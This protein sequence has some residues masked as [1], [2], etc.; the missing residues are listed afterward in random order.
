MLGHI[1]FYKIGKS[2]VMKM[3]EKKKFRFVNK[4]TSNIKG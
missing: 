3:S 4:N 2:K 1:I